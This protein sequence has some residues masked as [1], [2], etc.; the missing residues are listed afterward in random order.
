MGNMIIK[1]DTDMHISIHELDSKNRNQLRELIG[2]E[3]IEMV[4]PEFLYTV[5]G[6]SMDIDEETNV[7][8]AVDE[9]GLCHENNELNPVGTQ[10]YNGTIVGNI[11][12]TS[13]RQSPEGWYFAG[14]DDKVLEK[15]VVQIEEMTEDWK[16]WKKSH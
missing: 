2:C 14:L 13:C 4:V 11:L 8:M 6:H 10:L 7:V 5:L 9:E 1:V 15:L 3:Y 12:F 16:K